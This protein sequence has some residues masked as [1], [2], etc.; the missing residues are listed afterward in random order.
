MTSIIRLN[1][2][3]CS[4]RRP[5]A[6]F[7]LAD[8]HM[9]ATPEAAWSSGGMPCAAPI[10]SPSMQPQP[11]ASPALFAPGYGAEQAVMQGASSGWDAAGTS[12]QEGMGGGWQEEAPAGAYAEALHVMTQP[13]G[14]PPVGEAEG[15]AAVHSETPV[16][17]SN[18]PPL[19]DRS[20]EDPEG[21]YA[22]LLLSHF[23]VPIGSVADVSSTTHTH[24]LLWTQS[25]VG[26]F[27]SR[28]LWERRVVPWRPLSATLV[29]SPCFPCT[30]HD[31]L[32]YCAWWSP[33]PCPICMLDCCA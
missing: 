28:V 1:R 12:G 8:P 16:P 4:T 7:G 30:P 29:I 25:Q 22:R 18:E 6:V 5:A 11:T 33:H 13:Q 26:G 32:N 20:E 19:V 23:R 3:A 15:Q 9:L 31:L 21:A 10:A 2:S 17:T 24:V 14:H 27:S